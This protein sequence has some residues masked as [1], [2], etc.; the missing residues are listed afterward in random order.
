MRAPCNPVSCINTNRIVT[1]AFEKDIENK[2]G[3]R[4]NNQDE[5]GFVFSFLCKSELDIF[6]STQSEIVFVADATHKV[7]RK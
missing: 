6:F 3:E 1:R 7:I 4:K 5:T 2:E